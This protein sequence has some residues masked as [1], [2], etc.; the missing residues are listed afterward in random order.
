MPS[1]TQGSMMSTQSFNNFFIKVTAQSR[2]HQD[3]HAPNMGVNM[4]TIDNLIL[5]KLKN[6]HNM[7]P[8]LW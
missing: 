8:H 4:S 5:K 2:D 6:N 7:V 3:L 1:L